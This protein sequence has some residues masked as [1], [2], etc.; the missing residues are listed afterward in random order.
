MLVFLQYLS[1][2]TQSVLFIA[3]IAALLVHFLV[4]AEGAK[5]TCPQIDNVAAYLVPFSRHGEPEEPALTLFFTTT[6]RSAC[7]C[8]LHEVIR[9]RPKLKARV[10][11][12]E[13][14]G[15]N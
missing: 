7:Q 4:L 12:C 11:R 8:S 6:D 14:H 13:H 1:P 10:N 5:R 15:T 2:H 3:A 9:G